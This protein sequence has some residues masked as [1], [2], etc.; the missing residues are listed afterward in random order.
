[1]G[2]IGSFVIRLE[3]GGSATV[4]ATDVTDPT[5]TA[6]TSSAIPVADTA[7]V[8]VD[9]A[10]S[11]NQDNTLR[12]PAPG[13]VAN[14]VDAE[15][16]AILIVAPRPISGPTHGSLTLAAD[17]SFTYTPVSGYVGTDSFTYA[18]GAG[19]LTSSAATVT[20]DVLSAA[21]HSSAD[22]PTSFDSSRSLALSFP[23]YAP[24]GSIVTGATFRHSYRSETSGDTTCYFFE[25]Y[26][27]P[28]LL[29]THGSAGSPV[30]CNAGSTFVTDVVSMPEINT[31]AEANDVT[32][33]LYVWNSAGHRS[34]HQLATLGISY[35]AD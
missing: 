28:T 13:V 16:Q 29:A 27:G 17:G 20:I 14:D 15:G 2:G 34:V 32:V 33:V 9:D 25:V 30:S 31:I 35:Y 18:I 21:Y 6:S 7:P 22:W 12:V 10:F 24:A 19:T 8:A 3:T 26:Q 11:V 1:V 23:A 4:T 5:K